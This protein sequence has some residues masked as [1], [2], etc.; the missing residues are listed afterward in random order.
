MIRTVPVHCVWGPHKQ[1]SI[2]TR[3]LV[4][5][6]QEKL[7]L[8]NPPAKSTQFYEYETALSHNHL[9][10]IHS[11]VFAL[12][13]ALAVRHRKGDGMQA[14]CQHRL[15]GVA[16]IIIQLVAGFLFHPA[17]QSQVGKVHLLHP[18]AAVAQGDHAA[19]ADEQGHL[20]QVQIDPVA[21]LLHGNEAVVLCFAKLGHMGFF[22]DRTA[23]VAPLV[24][25]IIE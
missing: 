25:T 10:A 16:V 18:F 23:G 17:Q 11:E 8:N 7:F 3:M 9:A 14:V 6:L 1:T 4:C 24:D 19:L 5:S 2:Q 12:G 22:S 13:N 20:I 15:G 21:A